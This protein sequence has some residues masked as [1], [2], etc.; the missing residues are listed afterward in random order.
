MTLQRLILATSSTD[1]HPFLAEKRNLY[2][3]FSFTRYTR[4]WIEIYSKRDNP[5]KAFTMGQLQLFFVI[6]SGPAEALAFHFLGGLS[7]KD[8]FYLWS[9][10]STTG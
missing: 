2:R 9:I 7:G 10:P 6:G 5:Y 1:G 4:V 8:N 3:N